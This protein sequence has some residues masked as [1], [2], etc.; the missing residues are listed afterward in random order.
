MTVIYGG[1]A[2]FIWYFNLNQEYWSLKA[3]KTSF[4]YVAKSGIQGFRGK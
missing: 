3:K 4:K 2:I 1:G